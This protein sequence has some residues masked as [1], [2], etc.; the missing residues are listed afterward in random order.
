METR[1]C[2]WVEKRCEGTFLEHSELGPQRDGW[3]R[4]GP[5]RPAAGRI[6]PPRDKSVCERGSCASLDPGS[7]GVS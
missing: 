2:G 1:V 6:R 7:A 4:L 5:D 3:A